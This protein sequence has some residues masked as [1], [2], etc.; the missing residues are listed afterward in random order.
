MFV[1]LPTSVI[2]QEAT[3]ERDQSH[4]QRGN[5]PVRL[6]GFSRLDCGPASRPCAESVQLQGVVLTEP[7]ASSEISLYAEPSR[8]DTFAFVLLT[9][10]AT[11]CKYPVGFLMAVRVDGS[12]TEK[13]VARLS[14]DPQPD[15]SCI[16][17]L[18]TVFARPDI[19]PLT[20]A[21][22]L[23]LTLPTGTVVLPQ[24]ALIYL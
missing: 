8:G 1:P 12:V 19:L 5:G 17:A 10:T 4:R 20:G 7:G 15:G 3:D 21:A 9:D 13:R 18:A 22:R 23:G 24:A 16:E 11:G 2:G 14:Q 6:R